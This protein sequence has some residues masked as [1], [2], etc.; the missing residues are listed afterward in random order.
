[1]NKKKWMRLWAI[2]LTLAMLMT[3]VAFAT[4]PDDD[5]VAATDPYD[6][7]G[8]ETTGGATYEGDL[9]DEIVEV[10][11]PTLSEDDETFNFI[12]DPNK[13]LAAAGASGSLGDVT[14]GDGILF[15][16][17]ADA[18]GEI[19]SYSSSSD[20]LTVVNKSTESVKVTLSVAI[21]TAGDYT[22]STTKDFSGD[23]DESHLYLA[24][25]AGEGDDAETEVLASTGAEI[26]VTV[27]R[28]DSAFE[29]VH[30]GTEYKY[31]LTTEAS[32][33]GYDGWQS[34]SFHMEGAGNENAEW[35]SDD[36]AIA[37]TVE[38]EV[39]AADD[40]DEKELSLVIAERAVGG[41]GGNAN[42]DT[43]PTVELVDQATGTSAATGV[44]LKWTAGTGAYEDY[45]FSS[46]TYD[47][48]AASVTDLGDNQFRLRCTN[49]VRA[50]SEIKVVFTDG[51]NNVEVD[52]PDG[53]W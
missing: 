9:P 13:L 2:V 39:S 38:W 11:L 1:M 49:T 29:V 33:A 4:D 24:L 50:A 18:D 46:V 21:T 28:T 27:G 44:V 52:L 6:D 14:F 17:N 8:G 48:T 30:D 26:E 12:V 34:T 15:F 19:S 45:A 5:P 53:C 35:S 42:T 47:G 22:L 36:T 31:Q 41:G 32:A 37:F 51:A 40:E 20:S 16:P 23:D 43:E 7:L 3:T 25:V 10:V